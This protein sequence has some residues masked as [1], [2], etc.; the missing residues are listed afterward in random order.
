MNADESG[1]LYA[2]LIGIDNYPQRPLADGTFYPPLGGCVRDIKRVERFL[3][4]YLG[5]PINNISKL[6][7][8]REAGGSLP[9]P[10]EERPTYENMVARFKQLTDNAQRGDR[11]Y[12]HYS[13]HGGRT[14]TAF[15][16]LK[17]EDG[18]DEALVP[19]H[20][21]NPEARYLRD[22]ELAALLKAMVDKGLIVTLVLDCC[23]SGGATKGVG[24]ATVRGMIPGPAGF[25]TRE[26]PADSAV[27]SLEELANAW[28]GSS[29][30]LVRAVT[31]IGHWLSDIR[32]YTL[33]AAC[34]PN[35]LAYE[36]SFDGKQ[37]DGALTYWLMDALYSMRSKTTYKDLHDWVLAK[38]RSQFE[39][40]TPQLEG[41][42]DRVVF[43][44]NRIAPVYPIPILEV[45][46]AG[47]RVKLN[48]GEVHGLS[49]GTL[50][51]AYPSGERDLIAIEKRQALLEVTELIGDT[52]SWAGIIEDYAKGAIEP[53]GQAVVLGHAD[54]RLQRTVGLA[55]EDPGARQALETAIAE[56]GARF[57]RL[58]GENQ[59]ID[60][61]VAVNPARTDE[62]E[63]WE[64]ANVA[65]ANLRPAIKIAQPDAA[66]RVVERL[67]H[68]A[69]YR[70]IQE[71]TNPDPLAG[72]VKFELIDVAPEK[73]APDGVPIFAPG[74]QLKVKIRNTIEPNPAN[75]NDPTRILNITV[76]DLAPDW[77][78]QQVFPAGAGAFESLQPGKS[79]E[80]LGEAYLPD[81]YEEGTDILKV[82]AT[83]RTSGFRCLELPPLD[84]PS[85]GRGIVP[86]SKD[87]L[88]ALLQAFTSPEAPIVDEARTRNI[89]LLKSK[90][91]AWVVA[92]VEVRVKRNP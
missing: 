85:P 63:I 18:L 9:E 1:S 14:R 57:I 35:E 38:I 61:Q 55:I 84:Q 30:S 53:G 60:F 79:I 40:Q 86:P 48:A 22:I 54:P 90:D 89:R 59:P 12:I 31:S 24:T 91:G 13:G 7:A 33:L 8:T 27:A 81:G 87:P 43:G 51:A 16:D 78:V 15:K 34:R 92:H 65:V 3:L 83:Q 52:D 25:D 45:D 26:P 28:A 69:K 46:D 5:I 21:A 39:K 68:L 29:R 62:Y 4:D 80:F 72:K 41:E 17:G 76:L 64:R 71:L 23:H 82:F 2:L 44:A 19:Y 37:K 77:Q 36:D 66:R 49:V 75:I 42:G 47:K 67:V 20:I 6:T 56:H 88:E 32:G 73:M 11:I 50:L 74:D 70:K 10:D 58:A